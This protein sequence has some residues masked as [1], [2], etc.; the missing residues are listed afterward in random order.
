MEA[1]TFILEGH[2]RK[3]WRSASA[4]LLQEQGHVL[5]TDFRRLFTQLHFSPAL[6]QVKAIKF[7]NLKQ[8][9]MT[10]YEYQ[11]KFIDLLPFF[12]YIGFSSEA[13]YDHF[14]QGLNHEI[15]DREEIS[16]SRAKFLQ[17]SRPTSSLGPRAQLFKNQGSTSSS[18]GSS[19]VFHF[20]KKKKKGRCEHCGRKHPFD[21]CHHVSGACL[22]AEI[23]AIRRR[24]VLTVVDR[25]VVLRPS[26]NS[27]L[28]QQCPQASSLGP[29]NLRPHV[30]GQVFALNQDHAHEDI[31]RMISGTFLLFCISAYVLIDTDESHSFISARF[32]K[33]FRL[34]YISLNLL[35]VVSTPMGQEVLAK[36]RVVGCTLEF[37]GHQLC[38]NLM[39]LVMDD[40]ECIIRID[41]LTSYRAIVDCYQRFVQFRPE[42][43][44]VWYF[45]GEEARPL[46]LIVCALRAFRAL[47]SGGEGYFIYAI[48]TSSEGP[49]IQDIPVV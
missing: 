45:Y 30:Q 37:E 26:F 7:L 6:H 2:A 29:S 25:V 34:P 28:I 9:S 33:N 5:W 43:G 39:V 22:Y 27:A 14:L 46:M 23:W 32:I 35:L 12:P 1:D 44:D 15:F 18:F 40:F 17:S 4:Q 3:W 31:E 42:D 16:V 20:G 21:E 36:R 48:D 41:L 8:G 47:K 38:A 11:Q 24:I 13:K 49:D 10:I 19:G